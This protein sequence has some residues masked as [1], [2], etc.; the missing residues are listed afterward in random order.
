M[1]NY[2]LISVFCLAGLTGGLRGDPFLS[3]MQDFEAGTKY[4]IGSGSDAGFKKF[5]KKIIQ[6]GLLSKT[7]E[8]DNTLLHRI[9]MDYCGGLNKTKNI[10]QTGMNSLLKYAEWIVETAE[11]NLLLVKENEKD[12]IP[13]TLAIE[14]SIELTKLF[15][16]KAGAKGS[17]VTQT[18]LLLKGLYQYDSASEMDKDIVEL[19][20]SRSDI[21]YG[22]RTSKF[23]NILH[24]AAMTEELKGFL[25]SFLKKHMDIAKKLINMVSPFGAPLH[26]AATSEQVKMLLGVEGINVNQT[27]KTGETPLQHFIRNKKT[28]R[29]DAL[30]DDKRVDVKTKIMVD[31]KEICP[32]AYAK[33]KLGLE[34]QWNSIETKMIKLGA[35]VCGG[36]KKEEPKPELSSADIALNDFAYQLSTL[37]NKKPKI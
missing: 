36:G 3:T 1:K 25:A 21:N 28:A 30:L 2:L 12:K 33:K 6:G 23:N 27:N 8:Q 7:D 18:E 32:L 29:V 15:L 5:D 19:L 17:G 16:D 37:M 35:E 26:S 13:F 14:C 9:V 34:K 22:E 24:F 4:D 31:K 20:V 10:T 11:G